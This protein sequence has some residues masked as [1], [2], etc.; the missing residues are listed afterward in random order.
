MESLDDVMTKKTSKSLLCFMKLVDPEKK[1][2]FDTPLIEAWNALSL[3]EQRKL[4]L[5]YLYNKF[6]PNIKARSKLQKTI[7]DEYR[8]RFSSTLSRLERD[9]NETKT[10]L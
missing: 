1:Y 4:Y 8:Q 7:I 6:A 2:G 5:V 10:R 9:Y 3:E